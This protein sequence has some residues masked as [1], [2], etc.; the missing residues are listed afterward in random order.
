M[1]AF[2]RYATVSSVRGVGSMVIDHA[3]NQQLGGTI[4]YEWRSEGMKCKLL[5]PLKA[6][7]A[8]P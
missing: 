5:V 7:A 6:P 1:L 8:R 3:I 2:G 4:D